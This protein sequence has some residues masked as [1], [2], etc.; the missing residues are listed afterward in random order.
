MQV[1]EHFHAFH[2][3]PCTRVFH[4]EGDILFFWQ[5]K[6]N[7]Q[8]TRRNNS[9][10]RFLHLLSQEDRALLS[11]IAP[12]IAPH[13]AYNRPPSDFD[14]VF[15]PEISHC[16]IAINSGV[17]PDERN[18]ASGY[19]EVSS[20]RR[21]IV[22]IEFR[23]LESGRPISRTLITTFSLTRRLIPASPYPSIKRCLP[24]VATLA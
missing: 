2:Q 12:R 24:S 1:H 4:R 7:C 16:R 6:R 13:F 23:C 14:W 9:P 5:S 18:C 20:I 22:L 10:S 15:A 19:R 3:T 11:S 8:L 17:T 21:V